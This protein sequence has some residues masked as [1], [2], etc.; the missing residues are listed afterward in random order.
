MRGPIRPADSR[1]LW[2]IRDAPA[3]L[4]SWLHTRRDQ[5]RPSE[6]LA[7]PE[8]LT[9]L[10][11]RDLSALPDLDGDN[12]DFVW[13]L[14]ED[15]ADDLRT[16]I[17]HRG[18]TLWT[19]PAIAH[20]TDRFSEVRDLLRDRYGDRLRLLLA[21]ERALTYLYVAFRTTA[22]DVILTNLPELL[23]EHLAFTA[24]YDSDELGGPHLHIRSGDRLVW[25]ELSSPHQPDFWWVEHVGSLRGAGTE[26]AST[27]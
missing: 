8:K 4:H 26:N 12:L 23:G 27:A 17:R 13:D 3:T 10:T 14:V 19:E 7:H 21:T 6:V 20:G 2:R 24:S 9:D 22:D 5:A 25:R 15:K 18:E 16:V 11:G 1:A